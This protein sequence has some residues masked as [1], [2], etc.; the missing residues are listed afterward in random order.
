MANSEVLIA[1]PE[2]G[3]KNDHTY[4]RPVGGGL[5]VGKKWFNQ[6]KPEHSSYSAVE[7]R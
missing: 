3:P 6:A 1:G 5:G 2:W 4:S 7:R